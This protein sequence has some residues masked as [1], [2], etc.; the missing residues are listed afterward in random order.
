MTT[1][2]CFDTGIPNLA[3]RWFVDAGLLLADARVS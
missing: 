2:T 3:G 1:H